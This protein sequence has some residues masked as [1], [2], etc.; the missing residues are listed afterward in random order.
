[1]KVVLRLRILFSATILCI[2]TVG[3]M[4][5]DKNWIVNSTPGTDF[6]S[7]ANWQEG[8]PPANDTTTD[9]AIFASKTGTSK[10]PA[11]TT[12]RSV[13]GL[14][15][16]G[17][18]SGAWILSGPYT[19]SLGSAGIDSSANW[20]WVVNQ[21]TA[22]GLVL[23]EDSTWTIDSAS[24]GH[25]LDVYS[26][27]TGTGKLTKDG[28]SELRLSAGAS[29]FSGGFVLN[30][31]RLGLNADTTGGGGAIPPTSGPI[32]TGTLTINGGAIGAVTNAR[33]IS[34]PLV[35]NGNFQVP[36]YGYYDLTLSG[37]AT[38]T[39][40]I[41]ITL[42]DADV[43]SY[44][45]LYLT[46]DITD[47]TN[48]YSISVVS[49]HAVGGTEYLHLYGTNSFDGGVIITN[50]TG[51]RVDVYVNNN[52]SLGT[53]P[54][55]FS[56][57]PGGN[58]LVAVATGLV[59]TNQLR[60]NATGYLVVGSGGG[61]FTLNGDVLVAGNR[62]LVTDGYYSGA[63][64]IQLGGAIVAAGPG[65]GTLVYAIDTG[66]S[67]WLRLTGS[68]K[69]HTAGLTVGGGCS[70]NYA[71]Y[72]MLAGNNNTF[73]G[74]ITVNL[75]TLVLSGTNNTF[76]GPVT[77]Y[78]GTFIAGG[79][80]N[81]FNAGVTVNGG[82][83][84]VSNSIGSAIV[85]LRP[86]AGAYLPYL[87]VYY[88]GLP[89]LHSASTDGIIA[90]NTSAFDAVTNFST[91]GDGTL[92]LGSSGNGTFT[93]S[94]LAAWSNNT[95][96]LGGGGGTLTLDRPSSSEGVL[97]GSAGLEIGKNGGGINFTGTVVVA[98]ANTFTGPITVNRGS[99]LTGNAQAS[100]GGSP[101]G[102][103]TGA[104][105]LN[106]GTLGLSNGG[107]NTAR[108]AVEKDVL[109]VSGQSAVELTGGTSSVVELN[110]S[111]I[112]RSNRGVLRVYRSN[113]KLTIDSPPAGNPNG[114]LPC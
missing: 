45:H 111:S 11:L 3:V 26:V 24:K 77:V 17:S 30:A 54:L 1:M 103:N 34:N 97:T 29:T 9:I 114:I 49:G 36:G 94:A 87:A 27:I 23:T 82:G 104:V 16:T 113:G 39:R 60:L 78:T 68:G 102:S 84:V 61:V 52:S 98:D 22:S 47:G 92:W 108:Q 32:G 105:T 95:Y 20:D 71:P 75:G 4:R 43:S 59:F 44:R 37:N 89:S 6:E 5:A 7:G 110:V 101:F 88:N 80:N 33:T 64:A 91:L 109:T 96:R 46:G 70:Q 107:I 106:G 2:V 19:L 56:S 42:S 48:A 69:T 79:T 35:L 67:N 41:T 28:N 31:G 63:G 55:T 53:G 62:A 86:A 10:N 21:V 40:D 99:T 90:I 72:L 93:G 15:F 85:L 83:L 38:L 66:E 50:G 81:A 74:P 100:G 76:N 18:L 65:S 14:S 112:S 12:S 51:E 13:K 8:S 25:R 57:S 58:G 73:F